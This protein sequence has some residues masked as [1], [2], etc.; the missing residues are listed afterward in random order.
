MADYRIFDSHAHYDDEKFAG[1]EI[2]LLNELH[3]KN[4]VAAVLN[5]G[6]G[7]QTSYS[8]AKLAE[9]LDFVYFAAGIHPENAHTDSVVSDYI[10]KI[11]VLAQHPKCRAIGEIGLDYYYGKETEKI[12]KEVF[13]CQMGLA[14]KMH[15]PVIIHDRDAHA[16]CLDMI[17]AF[18]NVTGV[19]H[20]YSGSFEMAKILL[21]KGWYISFNGILTFKNARKTVEVLEAIKDY[22]NGRYLSNILV[23]TDAPYLAPVP[24]R[25]KIN[26][27]GNI[28]FTA[29]RAGEILGISA[30][31]FCDLTYKNAC[32]FYGLEE[33]L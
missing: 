4:G 12:Q 8:S 5:A 24:M 16:D 1:G 27:S 15:L 13:S 9:C 10:D 17:S 6:A 21:K 19:F 3:D 29:Q 22:E 11:A 26:N 30:E 32:V 14:E 7:L 2:A 18:P 25:G 20:S 31:E 33:L 28:V 23:E